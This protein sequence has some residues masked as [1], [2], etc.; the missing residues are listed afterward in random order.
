MKSAMSDCLE[1]EL[2]NI[3]ALTNKLYINDVTNSPTSGWPVGLLSLISER[4]ATAFATT[5]GLES[6]SNSF[7]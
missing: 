2:V 1:F 5:I 6:L 3:W 4:A 7:S